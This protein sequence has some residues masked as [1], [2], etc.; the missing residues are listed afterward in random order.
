MTD[1]KSLSK[2]RSHRLSAVSAAFLEHQSFLKKFLSRYLYNQQDIDDVAQET[3]LRAYQAEQKKDIEQ[4][5]A[6]LF[7]IARNIAL[8]ELTKKTR[9]IV[10]TIADLDD[11]VV[12]PGEATVENEIEAQQRLGIYC[13]AVA[14]LPEQCRRAYLLR[15]IHG[16]SHKEIAGHMNLTVSSIE[17]H[18]SKGVLKCRAYVR[19]R[20]EGNSTLQQSGTSLQRGAQDAGK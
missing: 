4:P 5:K 11:L 14:A 13:E 19:E 18:L 9:Q 3:Y 10:D 16:L 7:S 20:E 6:F 8:T 12:T 1:K 15:K 2:H 17:K